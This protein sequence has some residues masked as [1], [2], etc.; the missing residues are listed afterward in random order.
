MKNKD[1]HVN[2]AHGRVGKYNKLLVRIIKDGVCPFCAKNLKRYHK[3]PIIKK[4]K[5]WTLTT[6]QNP[7]QGLKVH[8]LFIHQKHLIKLS[9]LTS[10]EWLDLS[11]LASWAEKKYRIA[12]GTFFMRFGNTNYTGASV[13]HLHAH[14]IVGGKNAPDCKPIKIK[15]GY[16][17]FK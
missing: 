15:V 12:G 9:Q 5:Y 10:E 8:L 11:K 13:N 17:V 4:T 1:S 7:Y 16:S 6:N 14:L 3:K 2:L